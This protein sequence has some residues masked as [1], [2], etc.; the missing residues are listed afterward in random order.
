MIYVTGD[1]HIPID[2]SK[3]NATNFPQ[4]KEM[5][6]DDHLI[7]CGDFGAIWDGG[8]EDFFWQNWLDTRNFTTL[9]VDGN[10]E[11]FPMLYEYPLIDYKGGKVHK[12]K[13]SV[14]H[15]MRG[16]V[17]TIEDKKFFAMGGA[18][19]HDK[20]FR[21]SGVSWWPEELPSEKEYKNATDNL[22]ANNR[23]V[24][25]IITHCA[26]ISIQAR[27]APDYAVDGLINFFEYIYESDIKYTKW[28]FGHYHDDVDIDDKHTCLYYD[29]R[30]II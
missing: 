17:F 3:L 12:I 13:D 5:T 22:D 6:K 23:E 1:T 24:D 7:I 29:I 4:Q 19:S 28:Y 21:K 2:V 8:K 14:Y 30:R 11:N 26:P 25:Y 20:E 10:H 9:F 16:E 27:L 15:L 18:S